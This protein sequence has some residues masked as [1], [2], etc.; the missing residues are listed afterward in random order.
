MAQ[1]AKDDKT[2]APRLSV[3]IIAY[4]SGPTLRTCL[5]HLT[6]Q[7]FRDFETL[8]IDNASPDPGDAKIAAE[9]PAVRLIRNPEN[10]GFTGAG[11]QPRRLVAGSGKSAILG[12]SHQSPSRNLGCD[13]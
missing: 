5:E 3:C 12:V 11:N 13:F 10:L 6:A 1:P 8:V 4:N 7:S 2:Q 9:F